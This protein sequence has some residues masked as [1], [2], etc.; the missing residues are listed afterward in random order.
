MK[1]NK[2]NEVSKFTKL[3][4]RALIIGAS[5][6]GAFSLAPKNLLSEE[7]NPENLPPNLPEWTQYL[8][9]LIHI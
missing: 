4:R 1:K 7:T 5:S 2:K 9:S 8:L 6:I 3:N